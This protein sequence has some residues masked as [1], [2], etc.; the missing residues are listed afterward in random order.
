KLEL[1][2]EVGRLAT[3]KP[4]L[5]AVWSGLDN[6]LILIRRACDDIIDVTVRYDLSRV[7][8]VRQHQPEEGEVTVVVAMVGTGKNVVVG[9]GEDRRPKIDRRHHAPFRQSPQRGDVCQ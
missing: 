7:R 8:E 5:E 6:S 1:F 9:F 2:Q 3:A 4:C